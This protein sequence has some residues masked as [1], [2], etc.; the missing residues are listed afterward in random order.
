MAIVAEPMLPSSLP[1]AA[2]R[3]AF[4]GAAALET[5]VTASAF[6]ASAAVVDAVAND[7]N[8]PRDGHGVNDCIQTTMTED[9][10][11][12][13]EEKKHSVPSLTGIEMFILMGETVT[14]SGGMKGTSWRS[15]QSYSP[16]KHHSCVLIL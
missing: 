11:D 15:R 9:R 10:T 13:A 1:S 7:N 14:M 16:P 6:I 12:N 4:G 3:A 8:Q 5:S 2:D